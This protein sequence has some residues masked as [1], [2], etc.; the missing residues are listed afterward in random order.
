LRPREDSLTCLKLENFYLL[1]KNALTLLVGL[2]KCLQ[3]KLIITKK[4]KPYIPAN[5]R[6]YVKGQYMSLVDIMYNSRK[7]EFIIPGSFVG[8]RVVIDT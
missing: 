8:G 6:Y 1:H 2:Q 4:G 7:S 5:Y 3:N